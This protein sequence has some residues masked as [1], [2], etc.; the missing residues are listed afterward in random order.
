MRA[1]D[2][3]FISTHHTAN[4]LGRRDRISVA[5]GRLAFLM[6]L[7]KKYTLVRM[8]I[9]P[10]ENCPLNGVPKKTVEAAVATHTDTPVANPFNTLSAYLMT[11]ATKRPPPA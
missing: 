10:K 2:L 4:Y 5:P 6:G 8:K 9:A 11:A 3:L 1:C 7:E